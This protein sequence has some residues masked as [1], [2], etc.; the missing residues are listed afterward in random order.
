MVDYEGYL[1]WISRADGRLIGRIRVGE[2]RS[3]VQPMSWRDSA[4]TLD[5]F[6]LLA[7]VSTRQ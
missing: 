3:Y 7:L 6:G 4:L 2:A 1:H 5:K